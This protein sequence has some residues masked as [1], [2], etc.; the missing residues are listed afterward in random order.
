[1]NLSENP[2]YILGVS[3]HNTREELSHRAEEF[4]L[5]ENHEKYISALAL[6]THPKRRISAEI[7]WVP[8]VPPARVTAVLLTLY[9]KYGS[10]A[11][12]KDLPPLARA[13]LLTAELSERDHFS[14]EETEKAL[15][16]LANV[17]SLINSENVMKEINAD[18]EISGFPQ[19][20]E[21]AKV[22]E[23][24]NNQTKYI[25]K[26]A[27]LTL[28][29]FPVAKQSEILSRLLEDLTETGSFAHNKLLAQLVASYELDVT[30]DLATQAEEIE[31]LCSQ[32]LEKAKAGVDEKKISILVNEICQRV[33]EWDELA[34]P[35]QVANQ[36]RGLK[37]EASITLARKVRNTATELWNQFQLIDACWELT[38]CL[39][40]AFK[41]IRQVAGLLREDED[42]FI[43]VEQKRAEFEKNR[44]EA[45]KAA[46]YKRLKALSF[47]STGQAGVL[48]ISPD[49]VQYGS[50]LVPLDFISRI[51]LINRPVLGFALSDGK[52]VHYVHIPNRKT[53]NA[54]YKR[55]IPAVANRILNSLLESLQQ[56]ES[57]VFG[58]TVVM[59]SG[60]KLS[61]LRWFKGPEEVFFTWNQIKR[62]QID[63]A[64][65]FQAKTDGRFSARLGYTEI[66]NVLLLDMLLSDAE[67]KGVQKLSD[68]L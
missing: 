39:L 17:T 53:F 20:S 57:F 6:L 3:L 58:Q 13:N 35:V 7:S 66:D 16:E 37:H 54:F 36:S 60:V 44:T 9:K 34:Q 27:S 14:F 61:R 55:L 62:V 31:N 68:L 10:M 2:F 33:F 65:V 30:V 49:G 40:E 67:S 63:G 59:D 52:T 42:F 26:M 25:E 51:R 47:S 1:M 23:E 41:E 32:L 19:L 11:A 18:R 45:N 48:K 38:R 64:F 15:R 12:L 29:S 46:E 28:A 56:G 22:S 8:G 5:E 24:L 43:Q 4:S 50:T 21:L